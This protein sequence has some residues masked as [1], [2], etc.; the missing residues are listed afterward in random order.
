[1][2]APPLIRWE[3]PGV[4]V[5]FTTRVGG[6]SDGPYASLNLGARGDDLARIAENRR[7]ACAALGLDPT[8]PRRQPA[9]PHADRAP[10]APRRPRRAGR[11][12]LDRRA[13]AADARAGGRLPADR[14]RARRRPAGARRPARRLARAR[15]GRGRGRRRGARRRPEG[16]PSS[17]RGR[18]VLLRGR[19]GGVAALRRRPHPRRDPRPL[20]RGRARAPPCRRRARRPG[21]PLHALQPGELFFSH[22]RDG[23]IRGVQGVIGAVAG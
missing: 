12:A 10:R 3:R 18:P 1:M 13:R 15:R 20:D 16:A 14:G 17:A 2:D 4:V 21:R 11:R 23:A 22:R 9:A 19:A 5:A 7:R 8:P 6:V